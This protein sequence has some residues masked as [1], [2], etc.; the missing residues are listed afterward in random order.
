M[1]D[2][3]PEPLQDCAPDD[4]TVVH[5]PA[6]KRNIL[7][8][9]CVGLMAVIA[10]VSGL[11]VAQQELAADFGASQSQILWIINA[12]T[13]A[14][15]ALLMPIGAIGDR[16]GRKHVLMTGLTVFL[17]SSVAAAFAPSTL[18]MII[19][20]IVAGAGAA[21]IMP[22]T[23][24]VITS[25]F[26]A[27]DRAQAIGIWA[28]VAGSG[29]MIGMFVSSAMVDLV[30]W[31][32]LFV[33]PV[34][35]ILVALYMSARYVP[36]SSDDSEHPFDTVGSI[37]SFL[38][39][40]G[41]VLGIHE[42]PEIGWTAPLT[43][44]G[45]VIGALSAVA[46]IL[47]ERRHVA[48]LLDVAVFADRRL[49][50]GSVTL[51]AMFGVM[52]GIMLVLFPFLQAVI[53]WSALASASAMLPMAVIMM[54]AAA[55]SPMVAQ[56]VGSRRTLL[57][58]LTLTAI[59]L[60]I[61]AVMASV[62]GGYWSIFPGLAVFGVGGGLS[63]TPSTEAITSALPPE[64]QGVASAL[65]DTTR[66]VGSAAGVALLGAIFAAGYSSAARPAMES[67]PEQVSDVASQGIGGA[68]AA[69]GLVGERAPEL[70]RIAQES[71]VEAW[72]QAMWV[73]VGVIAVV[74]VF[75]AVRGPSRTAP[76]TAPDSAER[77]DPDS[78][79]EPVTG[80]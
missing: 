16:W 7:I 31:R 2:S 57:M 37:L 50:S 79:F 75:I 44:A 19:A 17:I 36:N 43:L 60:A 20:R 56:R 58:G 41:L 11:V 78:T 63:M 27:E 12:Y 18:F 62:D 22:V 28:G 72:T 40:G 26:P 53:G 33:L 21:M 71:L 74:I 67:F 55:L 65:N 46:F 5:D 64:K 80:S 61:L 10:S 15:A 6:L 76:A 9:M 52:S 45:L 14:L 73:G 68:V 54:P 25:T 23:L 29:G 69:A 4:A 49:A 77:S 47:W 24:S 38:A 3:S 8:A 34:V 66:E 51:V 35:L 1:T 42:G 48:P 13:L 30:T 39:I 32:W 59:G 70:I